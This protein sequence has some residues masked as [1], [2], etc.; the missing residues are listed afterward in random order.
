MD[1]AGLLA[2][3][4]HIVGERHVLVAPADIAAFVT[5]WRGRYH[6][7]PLFV[8]RPADASEVARVV[9]ACSAVRA[10]IVPQGGNT[11]LCGG[12]TPMGG[13]VVLSLARLDRI[14]E[15][16]AI[17]DC[18][19]VEAG[20]TLLQTQEA[21][22]QAGR[23]FPLSLAS[24]GSATI[25]GNLATNAGGV[26]VLRYGRMRELVLGIEAVLPDGSIWHGL[27]TLRKDNTGYDLKQLLIGAEGSL[28]VITAAALRLFPRPRHI[29]TAWVAVPDPAAAVAL[30]GVLRDHGGD[31]LN[32]FELIG[33]SALQLVL[34]HIPGMRRPLACEARWHV[35][36]E[37]AGQSPQDEAMLN[38]LGA[39]S[40]AGLVLD[41]SVAASDGQARALWALRE[42][43]SEA[44]K[45]EG[46]SIKHDIAVPVSKIP[47]FIAQADAALANTF[48]GLR[49]VC[50][51]HVGD[52]NLHYNVSMPAEVDNATLLAHSA[53]VNRLVHDLV[54][55]CEGS[56]SAEHG[57]GQ[58]K[59]NEMARYKS[60]LDI[61]LMRRI[62][63][64]FDPLGIM[65]PGKV[66]PDEK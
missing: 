47:S 15:V 2:R 33:P 13:E 19:V 48:P 66:L 7:D 54:A 22:A 64:V 23:L 38:A 55:G 34:S 27:R 52:G 18:M 1:A 16:D 5:D 51:G 46:L 53:D 11:G 65:N 58:L 62:K 6:G 29:A 3:L 28:G 25:G 50:F 12:A 37:L 35:L 59:R 36:A 39:A 42:N 30:I 8:V 20:C 21:A 60:S 43:I 24:E 14:R 26:H 17:N 32:A 56:I 45:R 10:A 4:S 41:A 31:A 9:G 49:I 57:I 44:Q 61:A 63:Q 40:A